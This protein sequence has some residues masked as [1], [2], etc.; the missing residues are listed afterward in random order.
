MCYVR[1]KILWYEC[2]A[3]SI[4]LTWSLRYIP[5]FCFTR[6][7]S[8][9]IQVPMYSGSSLPIHGSWYKLVRAASVMFEVAGFVTTKGTQTHC[10]LK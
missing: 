2:Y 4:K 1:H 3:P 7:S 6:S 10:E 8:S 9:S 5:K